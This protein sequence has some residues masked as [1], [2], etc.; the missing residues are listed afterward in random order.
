M[1]L[2][3]IER[4][5]DRHVPW[6]YS[7]WLNHLRGQKAAPWPR[8]GS[9]L[10]Q[11]IPN[12][13]FFPY[14]HRVIEDLLATSS[15]LALVNQEDPSQFVG[16]SVVQVAPP[17]LIVHFLFLKAPFRAKGYGRLLLDK[18]LEVEE[19]EALMYTHRTPQWDFFLKSLKAK[20]GV[21]DLPMVYNPYLMFRPP[22]GS[23]G[24]GKEQ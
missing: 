4:A 19:P 15:V 6:I 20:G 21:Y 23:W 24:V 17:A 7:T 14:H 5:G 12:G 18:Y 8:S 10:T 22:T 2:L 16:Y 1:T 11:G 13:V 9:P 3:R